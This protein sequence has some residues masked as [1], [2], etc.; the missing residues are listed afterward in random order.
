[1][2]PVNPIAN[3]DPDLSALK[4]QLAQ[5]RHHRKQA[6]SDAQ[7]LANRLL[8]LKAEMSKAQRKIEET[9]SRTKFIHRVQKE[10]EERHEKKLQLS[11]TIFEQT[12]EAKTRYKVRKSSS[13]QM[14]LGERFASVKASKETHVKELKED[15]IRNLQRIRQQKEEERRVAI[16]RKMEIQKQHEMARQKK[17][18][19]MRKRREQVKRQV[20]SR[21]E[22][23][24]IEA[25]SRQQE[26][27][28]M[29]K[30][31]AELIAKL[32]KTQESQRQAYDSLEIALC[33]S[34]SATA[35]TDMYSDAP[36][37]I[38]ARSGAK[39]PRQQQQQHQLHRK[40]GTI[41]TPI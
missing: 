5:A 36:V 25:G 29:E 1:M 2:A 15:R 9:K 23:E 26:I 27:E 41:R 19:E 13:T 17:E 33:A 4:T 38:S 24:Q 3:D 18:E 31:E 10:S 7:M 12:N 35:S 21:I 11:Q 34:R 30:M 8:L 16:Q 32:Q 37:K 40:K 28:E 22:R 6:E 14:T 39:P 20:Y